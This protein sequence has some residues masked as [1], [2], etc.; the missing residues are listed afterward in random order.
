MKS[1]DYLAHYASPYYDPIKAH[2]YY[3]RTKK[4][5]GRRSTAG[6]NDEGK[7]AVK[8]VRDQLTGERK[9]ATKMNRVRTNVKIK[10]NRENQAAQLKSMSEQNKELMANAREKRKAEIAQHSEQMK[11]RIASLRETLKGVTGE[12]KE[13]MREQVSAQIAD[14]RNSNANE[15]A[16]L[17]EEYKQ[18]Q[19]KQRTMYKTNTT[20]LRTQTSETNKGLRESQKNT[21]ARLKKDY[22]AMY[23]REFDKIANEKRYQKVS[24]KKSKKKS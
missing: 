19:E 10:T 5:K 7:A 14:L 17:N 23:E 15:R 12:Q 4:L 6:L 21:A 16:R 1:K 3:E 11:S 8:Y 2:E 18:F 13:E 22:D 20:N 9:E 24:K